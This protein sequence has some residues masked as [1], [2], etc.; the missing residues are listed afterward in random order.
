MNTGGQDVRGSF[1]YQ[2]SV[3]LVTDTVA[4]MKFGS[5]FVQSILNDFTCNYEIFISEFPTLLRYSFDSK[6]K[7]CN[8]KRTYK[9][10]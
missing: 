7:I 1:S 4:E 5:N 10:I 6:S 3:G 8:I 9:N 2:G